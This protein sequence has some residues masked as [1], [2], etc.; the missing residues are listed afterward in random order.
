M[1][2]YEPHVGDSL[3][4]YELESLHNSEDWNI[5]SKVNDDTNNRANTADTNI[6]NREHQDYYD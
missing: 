6:I 2:P 3:Q 1:T 4:N 5:L